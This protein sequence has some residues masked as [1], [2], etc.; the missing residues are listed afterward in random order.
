[1]RPAFITLFAGLFLGLTTGLFGQ[2]WTKQSRYQDQWV[3]TDALSRSLPGHEDV[4]KRREGKAVGIF[5]FV[6]IGNHAQQVYDCTQILKADPKNPE[7]GPENATHFWGEPEYGYFHSSD[8]WVIRRDMQM[9]ANADI[10]FIY[11]DCTNA[12]VYEKTVEV[13]LEVIAEM[14][15][16]GIAAP[17]V[18]FTTNAR[19][20]ETMNR[21]YDHFYTK[22]ENDSLWFE[23]EGKPLILGIVDDPKLRAE[24]KEHF[25]IKKSWAWTDAKKPDHWQWLDQHPQDY[26]WSK[27]PKVAEQISVAVASH[28]S[29]STGKSFHQKHQPKVDE[30]YLTPLT[31][32]GLFFEEQW[33]RAHEV[34]PQVVMVSGW[35]E[36]IAQR[37]IKPDQ[38]PV[39][40]GRPPLKDGTWFVDAFTAE[41]NRDIAPMRGGYTDS[42]YYQLIAHVR[43]FKGMEAPAKRPKA[44]EMIIDGKFSDW[45]GL[46]L[47]YQD[48]K[49]DVV[50]RQ[51]RGTDPKTTYT[52]T[53][54]R[55]D[56]KLACVVES[57][58][59]VNFLVVTTQP[60]TSHEGVNWM[61][62]L[63]DVDQ[64]KQSGWEGYD[65]VVNWKPVTKTESTIAR[66][67]DGK[68]VEDGKVSMAYAGRFLEFSVPNKA[69]PREGGEGF[70]FKWGDNVSLE[71][72]E[73][74]FLEG[75]V[76][77]DRRFNFRY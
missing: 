65:L 45:E 54:G 16:E 1:M 17:Q 37:F 60:M 4:G 38:R 27:D 32:R 2:T 56:I 69:F 40:A 70:D 25:T 36:W 33:Q 68:W 67:K 30:H 3:A 59:A 28:A 73:S 41:F 20:G 8:P 64:D 14:R 48:P 43:R 29:N 15:G 35:N 18:V 42:Y 61:R 9:L 76:A 12:L 46:D 22:K 11:L 49:G 19:S 57:D 44:R 52:N 51:F 6:W 75:D 62:L 63:I 23:W 55:N 47:S 13:L 53:K 34:D 71:N 10:D 5:Y 7:W 58:D 77:P 39:F 26:G 24:V 74:L 66:W 21:I 72:V 50:H 31:D